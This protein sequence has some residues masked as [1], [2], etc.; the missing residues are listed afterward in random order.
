MRRTRCVL[1]ASRRLAHAVV[2]RAPELL[3]ATFSVLSVA[4]LVLGLEFAARAAQRVDTE[5]PSSTDAIYAGHIYSE[6]LGWVPRPTARF[7]I[8]TALTTI[9][10]A[11]YRGAVLPEAVAAGRQRLVLLGDSVSFGYGVADGETFSDLLGAPGAPFETIN[12]SVPGYGVDQSL[13]RYA[14]SGA[15]WR[16]D[17]VLLN[18]C[19]DNDLA[20]IGLPAFLYDERHPKPYFELR[21]DILELRDKH[22]RLGP[23]ARAARWLREHSQL[24]RSL[25]RRSAADADDAASRHWTARRR[26]AVADQAAALDLMTALLARLRGQ[27]QQG[28]ARLALAIHPNKAAYRA[29]VGWIEHVEQRPELAGLQIIRLAPTYRQSALGFGRFALDDVGHLNPR[30]HRLAAQALAQALGA[31]SGAPTQPTATSTP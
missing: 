7:T 13:L 16:P 12:L 21:G 25:A 22:L 26:Q 18:V 28:G 2:P 19:V 9:N 15:R 1:Q 5:N 20:D 23:R 29:P 17:L 11:G 10:A 30:G 24:L 6:Y 3:L 8:G 14:H 27:V 4:A 31:W